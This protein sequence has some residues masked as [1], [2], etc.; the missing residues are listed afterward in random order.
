[1]RKLTVLVM[2][3][4]GIAGQT[5]GQISRQESAFDMNPT[6]F[7]RI[8]Y[9][10]LGQ[11]NKMQIELNELNDLEKFRN[12]DS[13]IQQFFTDIALLKDSLGTE[14]DSR[15][16]DYETDALKRKSIRIQVHA[17]SAGHY[18]V[19]DG[20][21]AAL[22][23]AQDTVYFPVVIP[24]TAKYGFRK[25]FPA[26]RQLRIGFFLNDYR[27]LEKLSD[28]RLN[29]QIATL[30]DHPNAPWTAQPKIGKAYLKSDPSI[31]AKAPKGYLNA[32]DYVNFR[33]SVDLQNYKNYFAP[34]FSLGA[35]L[36][37]SNSHF[38]RDIMVSWNPYFFFGRTDQNNLKTYRNDFI[39]L[40]FGQ[41]SI[42]DN[43]P[44]RESPFLTVMS[45][46][47]LVKREGDYFEKNTFRFGAGALSIFEGKTR[48]EPVM[49][50]TKFFKGVTPGIRWIQRF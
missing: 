31:S 46:G 38:K 14:I 5:L 16:I 20:D 43:E 11:G 41:G 25:A 29:A 39:T 49:Y 22:K 19:N 18:L 9:I 4:T 17:P 36:I 13:V 34:S 1:M 30:I 2:L 32:G 12:M 40:S 10:D 44:T 50:F 23:I 21:M 35:G 3:A 27:A 28:G 42:R 15:R 48:I 6:G 7:S 33:F 8:F 45:L 26:T 37:L 24:F 47:Y